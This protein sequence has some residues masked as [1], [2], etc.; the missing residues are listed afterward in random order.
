MPQVVHEQVLSSKTESLTLTR[1]SSKNSSSSKPPPLVSKSNSFASLSAGFKD[2]LAPMRDRIQTSG[3]ILQPE[4]LDSSRKHSAP[5]PAVILNHF[6]PLGEADSSEGAESDGGESSFYSYNPFD[7]MQLQDFAS[8]SPIR[9]RP[10]G[11]A[12][13]AAASSDKPTAEPLYAFVTPNKNKLRQ[14][15]VSRSAVL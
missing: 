9:E 10:E 14:R 15:Q 5:A 8:S 1:S 3:G 2:S 6:D 12:V 4:I 11:K 13:A 7:Y